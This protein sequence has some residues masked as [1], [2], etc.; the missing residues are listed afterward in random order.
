MN[1]KEKKP[2]HLIL[3]SLFKTYA[4]RVPDVKKITN[5]LIKNKIIFNQ[6]DIINDHIAFRTMGVKNLGI[7][8]FEKIFLYHGYVK[9]DNYSFKIK[10]LNAFWYSHKDNNMPRIFISE[11][12]VE[13]LSKKSKEIIYKYTNQVKKDPVDELNL[14]NVNEVINFLS[15]PLWTLTSL[16]DFKNLLMES[17]YASWVIY[18]RYYLNHYTISVHELNEGYNTLKKFNEFLE[19]LDI[20]LNNSGG[21]IKESKDGLLLQSSTI[22][23][24]VKAKFINNETSLI[25][26]SYVEFAERKILPEFKNIPMNNITPKHRRDGFEASNADKIFESTFIK[27]TERK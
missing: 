16:N 26:G 14:N 6:E 21:V 9:R 22:A 10:K 25:S 27:Q 4:N 17:E 24:K 15:K 8:S 11:L 13:E 7:K 20:K 1:F 3:E 19:K 2:I 12:K 23:N 18:N 5:A